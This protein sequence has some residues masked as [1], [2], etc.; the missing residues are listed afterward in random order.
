[1][2]KTFTA[3][4]RKGE[5]Y[6]KLKRCIC[7]N[8]LDFQFVKG[9]KYHTVYRMRD[10]EGKDFSDLL[11]VHIIELGKKLTGTVI[12]DWIRLINAKTEEDLE[13]IKT[14]NPGIRAAIKEVKVMSLSD[15]LRII[16]EQRLKEKRDRRAMDRDMRELGQKEGWEKGHAEGLAE[17]LR[18]AIVELL[19]KNGTIP[20]KIRECIKRQ[21]NEETLKSWYTFAVTSRSIK[22]FEQQI[23]FIGKDS[24]K[25]G[26]NLLKKIAKSA[27]INNIMDD[28]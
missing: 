15:K 18:F 3:D 19:K 5:D 9:E 21:E 17:G 26:L 27:D 6:Q 28:A 4:L 12:D 7:I 23:G 25:R 24:K 16:Y 22:A 10:G 20:K 8:I 2:A 13:M 14:D 1:M 11:E